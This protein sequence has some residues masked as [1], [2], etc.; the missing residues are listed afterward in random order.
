MQLNLPAGAA[1]VLDRLTQGGYQAYIVG[2][3][4]RDALLGR[5][6]KD[7]DVC[8]SALPEEMQRVFADCHVIETGLKHGT[9]TVMVDH[10][11][12]EVTTFRVD[13]EYTD[14]RHPDE[15]IFVSD[16][17]ED[18]ARRD[19]TV[20]AMAWH[21]DS[22]LVDA[23]GGREDLRQGVIRCVGEA[24]RRFDEDALRILRA[25]RFASVYGFDIE[26]ETAR[27]IHSL[28]DTLHG[29]AAERIRV[30]LAKLLCGQGVGRILREYSDV[31]FA[32]MPA[33]A[34]ME[35]FEQHTPYHAFD[36][37]EHTVQSVE[38]VPP[39]EVLRLTMLLHDSGKPA[40][41]TMDADGIGHA[42]G[43]QGIS[44]NIARDILT[45]L[46]VDNATLERVLLLVKHHDD[47]F[48]PDRRAML[49]LLNRFGEENLRLL[50][51]VHR[52]D[53]SA[54][55]RREQAEIDAMV[56]ELT[57]SLEAIIAQ[58]PC[59]TLKD[60]AVNGRDLM[61]AGVPKGRAVGAMLAWLLEQLIE[62]KLPN[63]KEALLTAALAQME[64]MDICHR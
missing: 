20:N 42:W 5:E 30:E 61:A 12:Y 45:G 59:V 9:L 28:K 10:E 43:H 15:V 7:W 57:D 21:P 62:E 13:G 64:K 55:G 6:P 11:P 2:G 29:V 53:E 39:T 49:R 48:A 58:K 47:A 27:A 14:H 8:T 32:I 38:K 3:C 50:L 4:V 51:H 23:F 24:E 33:L 25:L 37:W 18:L 26:A 60:M 56:D 35:G 31:I 46:K 22:G 17:V 40:A 1:F 52:A 63:E 16:V 44:V 41:F 19:F 54:K 36:V 34:P